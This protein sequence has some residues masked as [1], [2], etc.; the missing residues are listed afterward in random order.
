MT[1]HLLQSR[2]RDNEQLA[3]DSMYIS[4]ERIKS[5]HYAQDRKCLHDAAV[6]CLVRHAQESKHPVAIFL[7]GGP[8]SGKGYVAGQIQA[9]ACTRFAHLDCDRNREFLPEWAQDTGLP[10]SEETVLATQVEA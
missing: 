4:H 1:R 2:D 7:A 3:F 6:E 5:R 8:G 10:K 9:A